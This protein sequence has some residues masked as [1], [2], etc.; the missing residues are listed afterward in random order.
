MGMPYS[1][2]FYKKSTLNRPAFDALAKICPSTRQ[3]LACSVEIQVLIPIPYPKY[4]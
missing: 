2:H 4:I 3:P 1:F